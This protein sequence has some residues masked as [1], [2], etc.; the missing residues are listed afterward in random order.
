MS[1]SM[2]LQA[3]Q[4]SHASALA[5]RQALEAEV[6]GIRDRNMALR[7]VCVC[8]RALSVW[9]RARVCVCVCM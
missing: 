9:T 7:Q 4:Q 5:Q 8:A 6:G 3:A 1:F 2:L